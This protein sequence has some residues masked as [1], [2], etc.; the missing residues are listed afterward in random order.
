MLQAIIRHRPKCSTILLCVP[1]SEHKMICASFSMD[2]GL[3]YASITHTKFT[4]VFNSLQDVSDYDQI[5]YGVNFLVRKRLLYLVGVGIPE[6]KFHYQNT[7]LWNV[8]R[9]RFLT[10][11]NK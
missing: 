6:F 11:A 4:A 7:T 5:W 10:K 8:F 1:V 3:L 2:N 9:L